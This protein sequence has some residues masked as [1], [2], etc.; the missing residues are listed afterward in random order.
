MTSEKKVS[1]FGW[2]TLALVV[3]FGIIL[4][5]V[6]QEYRGFIEDLKSAHRIELAQSASRAFMRGRCSDG[7]TGCNFI[8]KVAPDIASNLGQE[9]RVLSS[10]VFLPGIDADSELELATLPWECTGVGAPL[11][12]V[13][14]FQ[15][16]ET[17]TRMKCFVIPTEDPVGQ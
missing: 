13:G 7:L 2:T 8:I 12:P 5:V 4:F 6:R 17:V 15:G 11:S 10:L 16:S 1:I 3:V 14:G 9:Y